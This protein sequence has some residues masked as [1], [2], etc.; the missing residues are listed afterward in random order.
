MAA[1]RSSTTAP[2]TTSTRRSSSRARRERRCTTIL[3][4]RSRFCIAPT[5]S[6]ARW[7]TRSGAP[8]RLQDHRRRPVLRAQGNQGRARLSEA[9]PES[10]RRC[11]PSARH[12]RAGARHRQGRHGVAR[13]DSAAGGH[14]RST[15]SPLLAGLQPESHERFAVGPAAAWRS[16]AVCCAIARSRR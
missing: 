3:K 4:T 16:I 1:R 8:A 7:K 6:R 2:A 10:A 5:R 13:G 11:Q 15:L 12:Q 9:D 14:G